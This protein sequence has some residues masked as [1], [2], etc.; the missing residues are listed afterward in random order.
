MR[1]LQKPKDIK[2]FI[3]NTKAYDNKLNY[4]KS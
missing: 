4:D 1:Y 3:K 2:Y